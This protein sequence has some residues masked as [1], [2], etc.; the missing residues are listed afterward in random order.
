MF[1]SLSNP[2][3]S[4][5][6]VQLT[7]AFIAVMRSSSITDSCEPVELIWLLSLAQVPRAAGTA[8]RRG[9]TATSHSVFISGTTGFAAL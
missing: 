8:Q 4:P 2:R 9:K 7:F 3:Q 5:S 1:P 6:N